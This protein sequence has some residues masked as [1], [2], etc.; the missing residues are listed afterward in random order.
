MPYTPHSAAVATAFMEID[1]T[2]NKTPQYD[3]HK[4]EVENW[5]DMVRKNKRC[6]LLLIRLVKELDA[7][8]AALRNTFGMPE[9]G[10]RVVEYD[11]QLLF[12][13]DDA[14]EDDMVSHAIASLDPD[15]R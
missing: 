8:N 3:D 4:S 9:S 13:P 12:E 10:G 6:R 11:G 1:R 2:I 15:C 5:N 7:E 14:A